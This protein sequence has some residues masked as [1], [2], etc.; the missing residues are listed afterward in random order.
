MYSSIMGDRKCI[1][2][3]IPKSEKFVIRQQSDIT[4]FRC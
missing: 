1:K 3:I 2:I 4:V